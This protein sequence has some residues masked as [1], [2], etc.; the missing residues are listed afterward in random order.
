MLTPKLVQVFG[1]TQLLLNLERS[2][3]L[4]MSRKVKDE[5]HLVC[6]Y[7]ARRLQGNHVIACSDMYKKHGITETQINALVEK[8]KA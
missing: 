2:N 4:T 5:A 6:A 3:M 7:L 8:F 1:R